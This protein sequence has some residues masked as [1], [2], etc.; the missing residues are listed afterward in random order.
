MNKNIKIAVYSI[1]KNEQLFAARW[2]KSA[3]FADYVIAGDTGSTD[4][5]VEILKSHGVVV[6]NLNIVPWRF[7]NARN[8]LLAL[9]P[10]DVDICI[11]LD[12][13]EILVGDYARELKSN[14]QYNRFNYNYVWKFSDTNQRLVE[15]TTNKIHARHGYTWK[16][17]CHETLV[18]LG[19]ESFHNC[20]FEIFHLPDETKSRGSYLGL[21]EIGAKE[22]PVDPR[23]QF[24][25]ARELFFTQSYEKSKKIFQEYLSLKDCWQR[26]RAEAFLYLAKIAVFQKKDPKKLLLKSLAEEESAGA[27]FYLGHLQYAEGDFEGAIYNI[28]KSLKTLDSSYMNPPELSTSLPFDILAY[29]YFTLKNSEKARYFIDKALEFEPHNQRLL[30]NKEYF[31]A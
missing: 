30:K 21:L 11:S 15:F 24:Y 12:L 27:Y 4:N 18:C 25:Y 7:D 6:H 5:T 29:C 8:A 23:C 3:K 17:P 22:N 10:E 26:E 9:L 2:A 20:D 19:E 16:Y 1:C 14:S 28:E 13:D 31:Y